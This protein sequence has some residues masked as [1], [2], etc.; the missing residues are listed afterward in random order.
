MQT[1][2]CVL[3]IFQ[4]FAI[5]FLNNIK[6]CSTVVN[7]HLTVNAHNDFVYTV[8]IKI[9]SKQLEATLHIVHTSLCCSVAVII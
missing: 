9:G 1:W 5:T 8:F 3:V 7:I 2:L 6:H 4:I